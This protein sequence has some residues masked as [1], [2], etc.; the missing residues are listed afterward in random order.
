MN[1]VCLSESSENCLA[2]GLRS[3]AIAFYALKEVAI[4][5]WVKFGEFVFFTLAAPSLDDEIKFCSEVVCLGTE[6]GYT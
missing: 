6:S 1:A 3:E 5:Y 4:A 2:I